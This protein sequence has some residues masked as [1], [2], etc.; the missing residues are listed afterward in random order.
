M[1][2]ICLQ[3]FFIGHS[4]FCARQKCWPGVFFFLII[5]SSWLN[6]GVM[7]WLCRKSL[8]VLCLCFAFFLCFGFCCCPW[9][10]SWI[11]YGLA[12]GLWMSGRILLWI[13][14]T[15][16][17]FVGRKLFSTISISSLVMALCRLLTSWF[18]FTCSVQSRNLAFSFWL[19]S[20]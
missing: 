16:H 1:F 20:L 19:S 3:V 7:V 17:F 12:M 6:F 13:I 14:R 5:A 18:K 11:V 4:W 10:W 15:F 8:R 9:W 2:V